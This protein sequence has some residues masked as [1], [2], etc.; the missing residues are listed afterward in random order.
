MWTGFG[1]QRWFLF[2]VL[3]LCHVS[4]K[5]SNLPELNDTDDIGSAKGQIHVV[6]TT[7]CNGHY[8]E[9]QSLALKYTFE[10]VYPGGYITRVVSCKRADL[11]EEEDMEMMDTLVVPSWAEHPI[12]HDVY[13]P[14]NRPVGLMFWLAERKPAAEWTLIV[15][16]DMLFR[17]PFQFD[18]ASIPDGVAMSSGYTY[19]KGVRNELADRHIGHIAP[20]DDSYGGPIGRR[21][22]QAG[23]FYFI[24]TRDLLTIAPLWLK[25]TEDVRNDPNA[26]NLTG[27]QYVKPGGRAWISEMYGYVFAAAAAGIWHRVDSTMQY[28]PSYSPKDIP[29]LTHYGLR[30]NL[31]NYTFDKHDHFM[32][33]SFFCPPWN[34]EAGRQERENKGLFPH[35]PSPD[36]I[37]TK[38][39][40]K[41]YG[42][43]MIIETINVLNQALCDRHRRKCP[44]STQLTAECA[45]VDDIAASLKK[46]FDELHKA[47]QIC[48]D[49]NKRCAFWAANEECQKNW[50]YM[51]ENCRAS[52]HHCRRFIP[53]DKIQ[54]A[55]EI[56][57]WSEIKSR[58]EDDDVPFRIEL[59]M[60]RCSKL[61]RKQL[62]SDVGCS[63][64]IAKGFADLEKFADLSPMS[65]AD[66]IVTDFGEYSSEYFAWS[67]AV[68]LLL[69]VLIFGV[70][71]GRRLWRP[72]PFKVS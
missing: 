47:Q 44:S 39:P 70:R 18:L 2:F 7:E 16:P 14:Y 50:K 65:P 36:E 57:H 52:C 51:I 60:I 15:D 46:E 72:K 1:H 23:A 56:E 40:R 38:D 32:F 34:L 10:K 11:L 67:S 13:S 24:R 35:P 31:G 55:K 69:V 12:T 3:I 25:Y 30:M 28:Y 63:W 64:L 42:Q 9:F 49:D 54:K 61:S 58:Q 26:W 5:E 43:L 48:H 22:D 53:P 62:N 45:K 27:D 4:S 41:R 71:Q 59:E 17:Q 37:E 6:T 68:L 33:Q 66:L 8:F 21:A 20:R 19:L 29:I